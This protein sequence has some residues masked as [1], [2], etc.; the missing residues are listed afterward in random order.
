MFGH[1]HRGHGMSDG[2]R[3]YIDDVADY[4]EDLREHCLVSAMVFLVEQ[5]LH[6]RIL[7]RVFQKKLYVCMFFYVLEGN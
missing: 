6:A 1:D 2:K 7:Y 3:A 5:Y 4:V